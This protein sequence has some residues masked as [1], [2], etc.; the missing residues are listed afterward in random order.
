MEADDRSNGKLN[1]SKHIN[2]DER[3]DTEDRKRLVG[4]HSPQSDDDFN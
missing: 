3:V 1:R 4:E 2:N